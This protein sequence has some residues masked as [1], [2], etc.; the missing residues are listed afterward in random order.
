MLRRTFLVAAT[1]LLTV[2]SAAQAEKQLIPIKV[3]QAVSSFSFLPLYYAK[4][5]GFYKD[6]GLDV[7]QIA[8]RGGGPDL[9]A[10][11]SG[12]VQFNVSAGTY[13]VGAIRQ[14][15][16]IK[17]VYN[18][19]NRNLIQIVLSKKVAESSGVKPSDP[20]QKRLAVLKGLRLGMTRAGALTDFQWRHLL[21]E[22]GM[23]PNDAKIVAIGG[24][25]ALLAAMERGQIDAY[26]ISPPIDLM[27]IDRGL[28]VLWIN[29]AKGDDPS[30]DP[31][32]FQS[33]VVTEEYANKNP[34][35]VKAFI[36]ATKKAVN[37]ILAKSSEEVFKVVQK[38]FRKLDPKIA[39]AAIDEVKPAFN[40]TG[41]MTLPEAE[42]VI[43]MT[44]AK[45]V[46]GKMLFDL[47]T[48]KYQ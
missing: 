6:E 8:T 28:G 9:V 23:T 5:A 47:Y 36:R 32:D 45:D 33:V 25:A 48:P 17:I 43:K 14:K 3:T 20:L 13:Q 12:D 24:G 29:N 22:G 15:R 11:I 7:Q 26:A 27:G 4:N 1:A 30:M 18:Y 38:D 35:V 34:E 37:E 40:K 44:G 46:T 16:K 41:E 10:L 2:T 39:I 31:F 42:N 21:R 19:Y